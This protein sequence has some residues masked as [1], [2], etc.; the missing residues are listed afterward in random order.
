MNQVVLNRS[1]NSPP[2]TSAIITPQAPIEI[3]VHQ[4]Q[5]PQIRVNHYQ[6]P[7]PPSHGSFQEVQLG[8]QGLKEHD[9]QSSALNRSDNSNDSGV[10]GVTE[11]SNLISQGDSVNFLANPQLEN[12]PESRQLRDSN[13]SSTNA[14]S[15]D[16]N[17]NGGRS[18]RSKVESWSSEQSANS[19]LSPSRNRQSAVQRRNHSTTSVSGKSRNVL[20]QQLSLSRFYRFSV[21]ET[22]AR[23]PEKSY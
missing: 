23:L 16:S 7:S 12:V 8:Q 1:S 21:H 13:R 3:P 11:T 9:V 6:R 4:R 19:N 14:A 10:C 5:V 17:H 20:Y 2:R 18:V 15:L 22:I